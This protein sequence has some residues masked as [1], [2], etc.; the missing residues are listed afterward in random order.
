V[1]GNEG[2]KEFRCAQIAG[3]KV[4]DF[5]DNGKGAKAGPAQP[6]MGYIVLYLAGNATAGQ[7]DGS[8]EF[9]GGQRDFSPLTTNL[10]Q[11]GWRENSGKWWG[12]GVLWQKMY[13]DLGYDFVRQRQD[14][15]YIRIEPFL[16]FRSL[17]PQRGKGA[18]KIWRI[19]RR[20]KGV[21]EIQD[22]GL[23]FHEA[24]TICV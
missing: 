22:L 9:R 3:I 5:E 17:G 15:V 16:D 7:S 10:R 11:S 14:R 13:E 2:R 20:R 4:E 12:L 18:L 1:V 19:F 24:S 23:N 21:L 6:C 8:P